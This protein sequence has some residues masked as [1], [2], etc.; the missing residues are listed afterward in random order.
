M[1]TSTKTIA[2]AFAVMICASS[3]AMAQP[4]STGM[5]AQ[6]W[7]EPSKLQ[8]VE[9]ERTNDKQYSYLVF[10]FDAKTVTLVR[11]DLNNTYSPSA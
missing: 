6:R 8:F 7:Q 2:A 9:L 1:T 5:E 10:D 3:M 11:V 4:P